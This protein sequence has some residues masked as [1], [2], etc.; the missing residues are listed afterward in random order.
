MTSVPEA[1]AGVASAV[2]NA[3]SRVGPQLAG[4]VIFVAVS[5][6]FYNQVGNRFHGVLN[7]LNRP[8]AGTS[9]S[10]VRAA[11]AASTD[12]FHLAMAICVVLLLAGAAVNWFGI[13]NRART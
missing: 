8:P 5:A 2:N 12:A 1:N 10:L 4:A 13:A 6:A 9:A 7:P 11:D 3:L